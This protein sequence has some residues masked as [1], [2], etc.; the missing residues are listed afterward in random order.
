MLVCFRGCSA[1]RH[2]SAC[3]A[4]Q[5]SWPQSV[6]RDDLTFDLASAGREVG[7]PVAVTRSAP[8]QLRVFLDHSALEARPT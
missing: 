1:D 2:I 6:N 3:R 5:V 8:V 4:A 7:G